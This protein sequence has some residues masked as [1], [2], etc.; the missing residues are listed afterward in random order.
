MSGGVAYVLDA[1]GD[2]KL[3]CNRSMV[4]LEPVDGDG[5][6]VLR[7]LIE[8]H[9]FYTGSALARGIL[10]RFA[11]YLGKFIRVMPHEYRRVLTEQEAAARASSAN[12]APEV[13]LHG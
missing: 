3:R 8:R 9:L 1:T 4:A 5:A 12:S 13:A 11:E 6:E 7:G 10:D 2:F